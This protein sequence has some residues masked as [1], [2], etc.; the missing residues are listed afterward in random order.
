MPRNYPP[1][2]SWSSQEVYLPSSFHLSKSFSNALSI[3]RDALGDS[4]IFEDGRIDAP[5]LLLG[6]M[7]QE[8]S[9]SI[10]I[11]PGAPTLHPQQLVDSPLGIEEMNEIEEM[12]DSVVLP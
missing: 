9:R 7:F 4:S 5:L 11:E 1:W 10:E 3:V 2:A 12:L 6:L 8:V